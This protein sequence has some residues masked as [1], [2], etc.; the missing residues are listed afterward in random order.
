MLLIG[1]NTTTSPWIKPEAPSVRDWRNWLKTVFV[2]ERR[3]K[4]ITARLNNC[5]ALMIEW[6]LNYINGK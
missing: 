4:K 6:S 3:R 5:F 1:K 2:M